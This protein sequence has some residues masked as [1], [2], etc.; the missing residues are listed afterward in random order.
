MMRKEFKA[1]IAGYQAAAHS[2]RTDKRRYL[3]RKK[4]ARGTG[5]SPDLSGLQEVKQMLRRECRT[6]NLA[7]GYLRKVPYRTI[8]RTSKWKD[9]TKSDVATRVA[10]LLVFR[11]PEDIL[12]WMDAQ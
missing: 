2:L 6:Y 5:Y 4:M 7:Y 12:A 9:G 3:A 1:R 10:K 8:E 11:K